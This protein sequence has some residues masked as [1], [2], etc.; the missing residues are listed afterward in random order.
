MVVRIIPNTS[1]HDYLKGSLKLLYCLV[2]LCTKRIF[3]PVVRVIT[4]CPVVRIMC[5]RVRNPDFPELLLTYSYTIILLRQCYPIFTSSR[6]QTISCPLSS[7]LQTNPGSAVPTDAW[8]GVS[9]V[10]SVQFKPWE[11]AHPE[12]G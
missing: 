9:L 5:I 7:F 2:I 4:A 1:I 8:L 6:H 12:K 10:S 11:W 3:Q